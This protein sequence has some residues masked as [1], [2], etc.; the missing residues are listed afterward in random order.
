MTEAVKFSASGVID[1]HSP[2]PLYYQL[3]TYIEQKVKSREWLPGQL[4][5]SEQEL[6]D[7]VNV[8]R[9]VVRKAMDELERK[10]LII[11]R[12]G[13]RT[14]VAVPKYEGTLMQSLQ[15]FHQD[16]IARGQHPETK[17]LEL[18][19]VTA[20]EEVSRALRISPGE[21][22]TMLNR[23]RLLDGV[24][25]VLVVTYL[26]EK[27]CPNLINEE[28][29]N[30]SL[31]ELL[32]SKYN[33]RIASGLRTIEA[34]PLDRKDARLLDAKPGSPALLLKSIGLTEDGTPLEYFVARHRGDR[35]RFTV[36]LVREKE[37]PRATHSPTALRTEEF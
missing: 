20:D 17:V 5:P 33:I 6:C 13:K 14:S 11:K 27:T 24:P 37:S 23:L 7:L 34:I 16:A 19:S 8:S 4:F 18:K 30:R 21:R 26:P 10:G 36:R 35:S 29:S 22:V 31:Y 9:T 25:E 3:T 1:H 15:G 28:F 32:E 2:V 12:N